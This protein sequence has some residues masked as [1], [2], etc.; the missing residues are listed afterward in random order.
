MR[1]AASSAARSAR[2]GASR[3]GVLTSVHAFATEHPDPLRLL[4]QLTQATPD[5]TWINQFILRKD[6]LT[7]DGS[8]DNAVAIVGL[9]AKIPEL[10]DVRL[11]AS[12]NR[13]PRNGRETFQIL[14]RIPAPAA[15]STPR[16]QP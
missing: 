1:P 8:S 3:S 12:V 6:Q 5:G 15:P 7:L 2:N 9:L 16:G 4:E 13:D 10:Q 11:G 14:A